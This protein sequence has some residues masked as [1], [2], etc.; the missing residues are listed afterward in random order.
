MDLRK[1]PAL[2]PGDTVAIVSPSSSTMDES[3][4]HLSVQRLE[5]MGFKVVVGAH[6]LSRHGHLAG[7]DAD[8]LADLHELWTRDDIA[9]LLCMRGGNGAPRLLPEL[10]Y[11][12]FRAKPKIFIGYSDITALHLAIHAQSGIVTFHGPIV[13]W[14]HKSK[15]SLKYYQQ[16]LTVPQPLGVIDDPDEENPYPPCRV[17]VSAGDASGPLTGGNLTLIEQTLGS[18]W[19]ID[20]RG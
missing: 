1:P 7:S 4:M 3:Q 18:P 5:G 2:K 10:D 6:A 20:T 19:E 11:D 12:L 14:L 8:R 13:A 15:Y 16:A 9:A 17:V